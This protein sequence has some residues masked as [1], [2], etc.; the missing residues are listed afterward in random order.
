MWE[1]RELSKSYGSVQAVRQVSFRIQEGQTVA[2]LG[3]S[4]CGK[5][6]LLGLIAGLLKPDQGS[7][8]RDGKPLPARIYQRDIAMVFQEAALWNHMSVKENLLFGCPKKGKQERNR[9]AEEIAGELGIGELL[10]RRPDEISGGQAKRAAAARAILSQRS[11]LLLDEPFTNLDPE[12]KSRTIQTVKKHCGEHCAILLVTH[13]IAE[14]E[15]F[16]ARILRMKNG[17]LE[18]REE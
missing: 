18:D 14:A 3:E 12:M 6:T 7:V 13:D 8:V 10:E 16:G 15:E 17:E 5:S 9:L 11:L 1:I 4:G 2:V